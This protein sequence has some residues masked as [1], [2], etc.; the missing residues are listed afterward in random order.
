MQDLLRSC[1]LQAKRTINAPGDAYEREADRVA[2]RV[3]RMSTPEVMPNIQRA[4]SSCSKELDSR[5]IQRMCNECEEE[6]HRKEANNAQ[7]EISAGVAGQ[8]QAL[9]G[10]GE[11]LSG[12]ERNFFEPRFGRDFS[13]VRVHANDRAAETATSINALAY[14]TRNH[15]VFGP[16]QYAPETVAGKRLLAHELTHI[17]QQNHLNESKSIQRAFDESGTATSAS[18]CEPPPSGPSR[19]AWTSNPTLN[20]IR[21][22]AP[23]DNR[24]LI[25]RGQKSEAV[26]LV[27]EAIVAWGCEEKGRNLLPQ[28]G[29]D[30][31]FGSETDAAVREFQDAMGIARDGLVGPIT[32]SRLDAF[33]IFGEI[34]DFPSDNCKVVPPEVPRE[35]N[36]E[37]AELGF[38]MSPD[39]V[40]STTPTSEQA[41]AAGIAGIPI[42]CQLGGGGDPGKGKGGKKGKPKGPPGICGK[43][44]TPIS[45]ASIGNATFAL[46]DFIDAS[47]KEGGVV[48]HPAPAGHAAI[49][50]MRALGIKLFGS[51]GSFLPTSGPGSADTDW[52]HGFIQT[53]RNLKYTATYQRGWS[54]VFEVTSPRRDARNDSV[55][56][57]WYSD[58][59]I[60]DFT[61]K[62]GNQVI[63]IQ[64]PIALGPEFIGTDPVGILDDPRMLVSDVVP[65]D[66]HPVCP[67]SHLE[68]LAMKGAMDTWI[69]VTEAGKGT[70]ETELAFLRHADIQ[71]DLTADKA[72]GFKVT[73]TPT[74]TFEDGRGANPPVLTG[75]IANA[76]LKKPDVTEG[77]PCPITIEGIDCPIKPPKKK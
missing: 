70:V 77:Q 56:G 30:A 18:G 21:A 41:F 47:R 23:G 13:N 7:A 17:V 69:V 31:D 53:I 9:E 27:Q 58:E 8:I 46:C 61:F 3:M 42:L 26:R 5:P 75:T 20:E 10:S 51:V 35:V 73:G 66:Q 11:P 67:C 28:F 25:R 39:L 19:E 22:E 72:S 68:S 71:F 37:L 44:K 64:G 38:T 33:V 15:I 6:L 65:I 74:M 36:E 50:E 45:V 2:D 55:R 43:G 16:G 34:P 32:L 52:E 76:D 4:C 14:T 48:P 49:V 29:A 54:T 1:S 60:P 57:P 12:N 62:V 59:S 63:T 24:V 40:A